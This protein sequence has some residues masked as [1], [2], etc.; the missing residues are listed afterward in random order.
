M[1]G[2]LTSSIPTRSCVSHCR[3]R[4]SPLIVRQLLLAYHIH[5]FESRRR[6]APEQ[7][8]RFYD[9]P[10]SR[11]SSLVSTPLLRGTSSKPKAIGTRVVKRT[12]VPA[13]ILRGSLSFT[14]LSEAHLAECNSRVAALSRSQ[15]LC[16]LVHQ[17]AYLNSRSESCWAYFLQTSILADCC[18]VLSFLASSALFF[19]SV[20]TRNLQ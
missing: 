11:A 6:S 8:H 15:R 4:F 19:T 18:Q 5:E 14:G 7:Y 9:R 17:V 16:E 10:T 2:L 3:S 1:E 12:S 20:A 13:R